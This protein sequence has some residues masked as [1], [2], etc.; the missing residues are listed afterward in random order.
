MRYL[1]II[2]ASIIAKSILNAFPGRA[3]AVVMHPDVQSL[4][5][6]VSP[7]NKDGYKSKYDFRTKDASS[8][9]NL[10]GMPNSLPRGYVNRRLF[11]G[12]SSRILGREEWFA[13]CQD[14][15]QGTTPVNIDLANSFNAAT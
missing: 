14:E 9:L 13:R 1:Y 12:A 3:Y 6:F 15:L 10:V 7:I 11:S 8:I 4:S 2:H 5:A